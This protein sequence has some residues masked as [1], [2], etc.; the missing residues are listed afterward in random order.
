[1]TFID[2]IAERDATG[3]VAALYEDEIADQGY[4]SNSAAVFSL[5]P[6]VIPGWIGLKNAITAEMDGRRYELVT[7]AAA[8]RLRSSYCMLAH[9]SVLLE[10]FYDADA[11]LRIALDHH[12]A[13][14]DE[15]DVAIMDLAEKVAGDASAVAQEDVDR[16][17]ELGLTDAEVFDVVAAAAAR[18]FFTKVVDGLG[19]QPDSEYAKLDPAL[20]DALVVG[21][22]IESA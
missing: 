9:G 21:R 13:G 3:E 22:P 11:L 10:R 18:A 12:A 6:G 20:L 2:P 17:R 1:M 14:L 4:V 19:G 15:V 7:F 16:L 5:R 8:R